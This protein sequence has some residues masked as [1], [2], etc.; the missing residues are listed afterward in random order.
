MEK[1]RAR[2]GVH[3]SG[4]ESLYE[5]TSDLYFI[6]KPIGNESHSDFALLGVKPI[7]INDAVSPLSLSETLDSHSRSDNYVLT[8]ERHTLYQCTYL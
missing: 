7:E 4:I 2:F 5:Q 8:Q 6:G 3:F 1:S